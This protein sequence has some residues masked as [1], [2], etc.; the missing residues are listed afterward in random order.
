MSVSDVNSLLKEFHQAKTLAR[1]MSGTRPGR[2]PPRFR[3]R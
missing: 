1:Q 3:P 2:L